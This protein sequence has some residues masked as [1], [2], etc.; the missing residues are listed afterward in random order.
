[1]EPLTTVVLAGGAS[2]RMG[3]PKA[4]LPF[5]AETLIER[6]VGRMAGISV[7]VV[8]VSGPHLK[9]PPFPAKVRVVEDEKPLQGPLAGILYGLRAARCDLCFICGCDLPFVRPE[10]AGFL[11]ERLAGAD[12]AMLEWNGFPQPL[13]AI[14]RKG[15]ATAL[16]ARIETGERR[17]VSIVEHATIVVIPSA[18][19]RPIDPEGLSFLDVDTEEAYRE[20]L[21]RRATEAS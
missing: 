20:A 18:E 13:L 15:L 8:V 6:V 16:A 4:L 9:L 19:L 1:V 21:R 5:G 12:G 10:I 17:A 2:S 7:E 11:V 3:R 14:Y